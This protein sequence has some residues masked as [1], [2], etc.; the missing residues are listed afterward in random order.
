MSEKRE[1]MA[2]TLYE[3]SRYVSAQRVYFS[4]DLETLSLSMWLAFA[5]GVS[6][7]DIIIAN[8]YGVVTA[9]SEIG[10]SHYGKQIPEDMLQNVTE[11]MSEVQIAALGDIYPERRHIIGAPLTTSSDDDAIVFGYMFV[12][13]DLATFR[14]DWQTFSV[15]FA[16]IAINV[17]MLTLAITFLATKRLA[18][19]L[20]EMAIAARRFARGDFSARVEDM[21]RQDEIGHLTQAFNAMADSLESSETFRREFIANISHELKTPMTVITGFAEGLLDGTI[22][23][24]SEK[25]YL[26]VISSESRRLARLVKGMT[27][28]TSI[29]TKEDDSIFENSFDLTE[30]VRLTLLSLSVKIEKKGLDV[31]ANMPEEAIITLGDSDAITQVVYNLVDN[32]IKF[33]EPG[34]VIKLDLWRQ[35]LLAYVSIENRGETIK[36]EDLPHIFERFHKGDKSRSAD[37]D[38]I[39]LGL[40][41]V[42]AILDKHNQNIF[43]ESRDG[44]T[45]FIFTLEIR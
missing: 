34:G 2:S 25:R 14:H 45:K 18:K 43:V 22:P 28:M 5:S 9:C 30:I 10:F 29:Q 11:G 7:F 13:S 33:S 44:S 1:M 17:M 19:P 40:Y 6:G 37:R 23:H 39:G 26:S 4:N 20:N 38:G 24:E 32:A 36:Q 15:V 35:G 27:E 21:D 12:S 3:T 16:L 42:K 8:E 31:K 41:I